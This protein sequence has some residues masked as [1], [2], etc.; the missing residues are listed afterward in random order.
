MLIKRST[1]VY[2]DPTDASFTVCNT[3]FMYQNEQ[4][5]SPETNV[6]CGVSSV[7]WSYYRVQPEA[8][9]TTSSMRKLC[10]S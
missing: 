8:A 9:K 3:A 5:S 7:N 10:V 1:S 6:N 2:D 4:D